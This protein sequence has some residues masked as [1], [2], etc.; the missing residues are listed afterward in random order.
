LL[1]WISS[2]DRHDQSVMERCRAVTLTVAW[3]A[4]LFWGLDRPG[5]ESNVMWAAEWVMTADGGAR[6][7]ETVGVDEHRWLLP[8]VRDRWVSTPGRLRESFRCDVAFVGS[9]GDGYHKQWPYR[10]DLLAELQ[11]MCKRQG[12][13]FLNPGGSSRRIERNQ[14]MTDFY[15]SAKVTVGDSLCLD[16]ER[17]L[18]WSDRVYEATGR[19]GVLIMP[20]IDA[21]TEQMP[22][23]PMYGWGDWG[24]LE[25]T[26]AGL[27]DDNERRAHVREEC[28]ALTAASHTYSSRVRQLLEIV[29]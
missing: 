9:A 19:G 4:D 27:L 6:L 18:Y 2:S 23:L 13:S 11:A 21:L 25:E 1:L 5:W 15:R 22:A 8:G 12:W 16:R 3:H 10:K 28:Q 7:W 24:G 17:S 29:S 26:V 20:Q 14:R